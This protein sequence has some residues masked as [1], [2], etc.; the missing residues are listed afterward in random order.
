VIGLPRLLRTGPGL[1]D[2]GG[3]DEVLAEGVALEALGKKKGV[4]AGVPLEGD[5]EH[6]V[7]LALVPAGSGVHG[8]RRR[9][10]GCRVRDGRTD[11]EAAYGRQGHHVRGDA[12]AGAGFVDGA[13]PV[14]VGAVQ[15]V[16]RGLQG[17]DPG[18]RRYVDRQ[19]LVRLLRRGLRAEEF[20]DR[21]GEPADGHRS[22]P[23][24]GGRTRSLWRAAADG[25][26]EEP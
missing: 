3:E 4:Q 18:S 15:R 22:S 5:A 1:G 6:L 7:G 13:Q 2:T 19:D 16:A 17:A 11:E 26:G 25:R 10:D 20:L 14:E 23:T 12:E 9:Q 24:A 21:G 8:D